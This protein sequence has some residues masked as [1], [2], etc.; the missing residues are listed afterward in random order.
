MPWNRSSDNDTQRLPSNA[1]KN[2]RVT[3]DKRF[4]VCGPVLWDSIATCKSNNSVRF[5]IAYPSCPYTCHFANLIVCL[6]GMPLFL[7]EPGSSKVIPSA[8]ISKWRPIL[9]SPSHL[10]AFQFFENSIFQIGDSVYIL[11]DIS[12]KIF[13]T[14]FRNFIEIS[15]KSQSPFTF[16]CT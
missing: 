12:C 4:A 10:Y 14:V 11:F 6:L 5:S 8:I 2:T 16:M 9:T 7:A 13:H 3:S 1:L 15:Y